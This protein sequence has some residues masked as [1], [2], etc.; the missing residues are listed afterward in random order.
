MVEPAGDHLLG[1][2]GQQLR[3]RV[4]DG[5]EDLLAVLLDPAGLR[6]PVGLVPAR[7]AD[8]PQPFVEQGR[9]DPGC[10]LVDAQKQQA[11]NPI[12]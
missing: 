12:G 3:D 6:M 5:G 4:D 2:V 9:L 8:R 1:R 10:P 7:F 11:A